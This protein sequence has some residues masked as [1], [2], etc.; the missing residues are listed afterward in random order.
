MNYFRKGQIT[1][2]VAGIG[3]LLTLLGTVFTAWTTADKRVG[4]VETKIEVVEER[5]EL[6]YSEMQKDL[7]RI[8][9]KIDSLLKNQ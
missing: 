3:G 1:P 2:L 8:E 7:S 6:H 9:S 5:E 4:A